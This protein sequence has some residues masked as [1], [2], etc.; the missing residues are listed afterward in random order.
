MEL[1]KIVDLHVSINE[2][3]ILKGFNLSINEGEIHAIMGPNG[4]GKSTLAA[5][6]VGKPDY[7]ITRGSIFFKGKDL[8]EMEPDE[9]ALAGI[10]LSFQYPVEI[11][12]V[13]M[14][15]FM[16]TVID[17]RRKHLEQE[18]MSSSDFLALVKKNSELVG[19]SEKMKGRAV[20][21]G[22][23]GGEK[24]KNEI[25]QMA[26]I[27]P[28]LAI[29]DELDSGLDIDSLKQIAESLNK[30]HDD[31]NSFLIITHYQRLLDYVKPDFVHIMN[32]GKIVR[33]GDSNLATELEEKGYEAIMAVE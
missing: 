3:E 11:P 31:K 5:A 4:T 27:N 1:L 24:K 13:S 29:L 15:N 32:D 6:L 19:I 10:F 12:G 26:M 17:A 33:S 28:E 25:F 30:L 14:I 16:K 2:K 21:E 7:E 23:S 20:N 18:P 9:R 8:L 22:F